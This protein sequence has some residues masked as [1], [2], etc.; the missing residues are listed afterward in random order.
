MK[1]LLALTLAVMLV[2]GMSTVAFAGNAWTNVKGNSN[3][4]EFSFDDFIAQSI[5]TSGIAP[6]QVYWNYG[7]G[8]VPAAERI[9]F[10]TAMNDLGAKIEDFNIQNNLTSPKKSEVESIKFT[11]D[12][13]VKVTLKANYTTTGK[14]M[15][16]NVAIKAKSGVSIAYRDTFIAS[17][18]SAS[19]T[20][21]WGRSILKIGCTGTPKFDA[22][23]D[24]IINYTDYKNDPANAN[25]ADYIIDFNTVAGTTQISWGTIGG[26]NAF[27]NDPNFYFECKVNGQGKLFLALNN[28]VNKAIVQKYE[29][30]D[31]DFY[32]FPARPSFDYTGTARV[33]YDE[34]NKFVY[35]VVSTDGGIGLKLINTTYDADEESYSW[36]TKTLGSYV[37]SDK[38]LDVVADGVANPNT[39]ANDFVNVAVALAIVSLAAAGAVVLK[40]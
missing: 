27:V 31:L 7:Y 23:N 34:A 26:N 40:K 17:A 14:S 15:A 4:I 24:L 33:F 19:A 6:N 8:K 36:K 10:T 37:V 5:G 20:G 35:E 13:T 32:N 16:G 12:D 18:A 39:G 22:D 28:D 3:E 9:N 29:D 38:E 21:T 2:V 30:A 1:K 11:D 25:G